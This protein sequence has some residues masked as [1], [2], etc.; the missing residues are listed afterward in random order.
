[1]LNM[2]FSQR[3]VINTHLSPWLDSPMSGVQRKPLAREE[4]ERGHATSIVRYQ[5]GSRFRRHEHPLGEEI[6]VLDGV[7]SDEFGDF[8]AGTYFRNPP[9]S[10]HAPFSEQGCTLLV[11]LH[12]F[13]S[14]DSTQLRIDTHNSPWLPGQGRLQ[15]MPLHQYA[16]ENGAE[17]VALVKWPAGERF[18]ARQH[19]AGEEIYVISGEFIDELGRY[20]AGTWLRSPHGS[21]HCPYVEQDTIIWVKTG[22]LPI[23]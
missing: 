15:V 13:F 18:K 10:S 16:N 12:Q 11:K 5:A 21:Q 1:M 23:K 7:F 19:F 6:L 2:D 17:Q 22:H 14:G 4:A 9:G 8:P 20:P 3:V